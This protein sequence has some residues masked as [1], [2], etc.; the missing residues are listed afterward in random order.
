MDHF[1]INGDKLVELSI[2]ID[3]IIRQL[4]VFSIKDYNAVEEKVDDL[5]VVRIVKNDIF[6]LQKLVAFQIALATLL[7]VKICWYDLEEAF[8]TFGV[9]QHSSGGRVL[10]TDGKESVAERCL[11]GSLVSLVF[12]FDQLVKASLDVPDQRLILN[13]FEVD[14]RK[15][16]SCIEA[17]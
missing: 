17:A 3:E 9:D 8:D 2:I 7:K 1:T 5:L 10:D 6:R 13:R 15:L 14:V 12:E 16:H 4:M 11:E